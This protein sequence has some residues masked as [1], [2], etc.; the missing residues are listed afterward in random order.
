MEWLLLYPAIAVI[1]FPWYWRNE[2]RYLKREQ[3]FN[4]VQ[5][6]LI[7][8]PLWP[9][10]IFFSPKD[11]E[12]GAKELEAEKEREFE[13]LEKRVRKEARLR[14]QAQ[15]AEF[16]KELGIEKHWE[17][18]H[19]EA[20]REYELGLTGPLTTL[21]KEELSRNLALAKNDPKFRVLDVGGG[22]LAFDLNKYLQGYAKGGRV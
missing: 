3:R 9:F 21:E 8:I 7:L 4:A 17:K 13:L 16:D 12:R 22:K 5:T 14:H 19:P 15:I 6:L 18:A 10:A 11:W 1:W 20:A 2:K